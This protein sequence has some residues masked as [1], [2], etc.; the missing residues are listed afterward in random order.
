[1]VHNFRRNVYLPVSYESHLLAFLHTKV[2]LGKYGTSINEMTVQRRGVLISKLAILHDPQ[3][4]SSSSL[5]HQQQPSP[6]PQ[7]KPPFWCTAA[8]AKGRCPRSI[9]T[10]ILYALLSLSS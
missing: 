9:L 4:V 1:M 3:A 8:P 2:D 7:K 5:L 10:K 6:P